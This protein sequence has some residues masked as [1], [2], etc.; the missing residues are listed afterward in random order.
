MQGDRL[1]SAE[2][3]RQTEGTKGRLHSHGTHAQRYATHAETDWGRLIT[4][5][6][7]GRI[8]SLRRPLSDGGQSMRISVPYPE[9]W[10]PKLGTFGGLVQA[11]FVY[12]FLRFLAC[13]IPFY[14]TI[15]V[16]NFEQGRYPLLEIWRKTWFAIKPIL[17]KEEAAMPSVRR[18]TA[19]VVFVDSWLLRNRYAQHCRLGVCLCVSIG[20][21]YYSI[22]LV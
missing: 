16:H 2:N 20:G 3:Y 14:S 6:A 4:K 19:A 11:V 8:F 21:I 12:F 5:G 22:W 9:L 13:A 10:A 18:A 15:G 17:W 7:S 1:Q